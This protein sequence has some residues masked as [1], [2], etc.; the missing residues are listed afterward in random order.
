MEGVVGEEKLALV[1]KG[2]FHLL[3]PY[4]N[5]SALYAGL[6]LTSGN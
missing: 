1:R 6:Q 5:V 3:A 4:S 2:I